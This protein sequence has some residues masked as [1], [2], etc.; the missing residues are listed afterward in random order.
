MKDND[1]II[2]CPACDT[3]NSLA[4]GQEAKSA[5]CSAC[6]SPLFTGQPIHLTAAR[7]NA[8]ALARGLP[9]VIDFW[10]S[11]C[12][13]CQTMAPIFEALAAEFEPMLRFAKVN[14]DAEGELAQYFRIQTIPTLSFIR[15]QREVARVAGVLYAGDLRRWLYGALSEPEEE[16]ASL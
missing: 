15:N 13:P 8:H 11:W 4:E 7:F 3:A 1:L 10:A 2:P 5:Q 14:T 16:H 9:L 6:A 12:G